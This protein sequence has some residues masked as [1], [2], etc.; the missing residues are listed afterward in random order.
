MFTKRAPKTFV[1]LFTLELGDSD[2][3]RNVGGHTITGMPPGI[4]V[5]TQYAAPW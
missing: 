1:V 4:L 2:A 5:V 3:P